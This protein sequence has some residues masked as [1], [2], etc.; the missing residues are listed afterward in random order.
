MND[1]EDK[2]TYFCRWCNKELDIIDNIVIH[3]DVY[4]PPECTFEEEI[5]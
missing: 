1:D 5:H 2:E 3:D 4:H